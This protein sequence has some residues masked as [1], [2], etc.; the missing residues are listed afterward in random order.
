MNNKEIEKIIFAALD[1]AN[2]SRDEHEQITIASDA[3]LFGQNGQLDSMGLVAL[4]VDIE[5][6]LQDMGVNITLSDEKAMSMAHSP[7]R[8]VPALT[9]YIAGLVNGSR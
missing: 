6:G 8:D 1:L 3:Q 7:F 2:Q 9:A 5:E 4:L